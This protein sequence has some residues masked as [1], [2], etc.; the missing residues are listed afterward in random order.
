MPGV[1]PL[2]RLGAGALALVLG[3]VGLPASP[4]H[5][6]APA[7]LGDFRFGGHP[8]APAVRGRRILH[9]GESRFDLRVRRQTSSDRGETRTAMDCRWSMSR[10]ATSVR[11]GRVTAEK[12]AIERWG[13]TDGNGLPD[14][15]LQGRTLIVGRGGR[16]PSVQV[17]GLPRNQWS[18][19]VEQWIQAVVVPAEDPRVAVI[20][21][22]P[23][24][25]AGSDWQVDPV[26]LAVAFGL[27]DIGGVEPR[28]SKVEARLGPVRLEHDVPVGS[29]GV[30]AKLR[31]ATFPGTGWSYEEGGR[32]EARL[33]IDGPLETS[34]HTPTRLELSASLSGRASGTTP[35]GERA[36]EQLEL[37]MTARETRTL[38][39]PERRATKRRRR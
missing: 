22:E 15:A 33:S 38:V 35:N 12:I 30:E 7:G 17:R 29:V 19:V 32:L 20:A 8:S 24:V 6:Q 18:E 9:E 16:T 27:L 13:C 37:A 21:P 5:A 10:E 3:G 28:D 31:F 25:A 39:L 23:P 34:T 11:R 1:S 26:R 14:S 2:R 4:A 36:V